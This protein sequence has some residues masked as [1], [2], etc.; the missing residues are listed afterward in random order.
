MN[1]EAVVVEEVAEES[2]QESEWVWEQKLAAESW[3]NSITL[4][5]RLAA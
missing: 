3:L 5:L 4:A 1:V 2:V